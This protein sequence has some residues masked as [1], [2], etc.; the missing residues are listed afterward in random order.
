MNLVKGQLYV[1]QNK[2]AAMDKTFLPYYMMCVNINHNNKSVCERER[3]RGNNL[4]IYI[5]SQTTQF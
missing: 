5:K 4:G 1:I 2:P 3:A